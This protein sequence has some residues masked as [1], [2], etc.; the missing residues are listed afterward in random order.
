MKRSREP[1]FGKR[2][3]YLTARNAAAMHLRYGVKTV[4]N[5]LEL[6]QSHVLLITI[7]QY[8]HSQHLPE[9]LEQLPQHLLPTGVFADRRD[10]EGRTRRIERY[11]FVIIEPAS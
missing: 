4:T 8:L 1:R 6:H 3:L 5:V 9:L 10:V 2:Y 11:R 7:L